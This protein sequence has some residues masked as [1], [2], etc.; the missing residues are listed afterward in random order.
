MEAMQKITQR[1]KR[2][3][4]ERLED[5]R[6][7]PAARAAPAARPI[8]VARP[9]TSVTTRPVGFVINRRLAETDPTA[10]LIGAF[11]NDEG[12]DAGY[13]PI[14]LDRLIGANRSHLHQ[15]S[16]NE[17]NVGNNSILN[18]PVPDVRLQAHDDDDDEAEEEEDEQEDEDE[19]EWDITGHL[20]IRCA[21]M[22]GCFGQYSPYTM[23]IY[24]ILRRVGKETYGEFDLG[25]YK[26][27]L[28]F[29]LDVNSIDLG[30]AITMIP[31]NS[32]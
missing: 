28:R 25:E 11:F 23:T 21:G 26:G 30:T 12:N 2:K 3:A 29:R 15:A 4:N 7:A 8:A 17:L 20:E 1:K 22:A 32:A 19:Y 16:L 10:F 6:P 14:A 24:T 18:P 31:T 9:P 13:P 5:N 27:V